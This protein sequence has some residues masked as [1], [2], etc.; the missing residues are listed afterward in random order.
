MYTKRIQL[1]NYGPIDHLD[2]T[3]PFEGD[4]PKPIL[5]VGE[6]GSGKSILL[7][8]IVNGLIL[9]KEVAFPEA[10]EVAPGKVYKLRSNLYIKSGSEYYFAK[11]DFEQGI[12]VSE[13]MSRKNKQDYP[14]VPIGISGT[15]AESMWESMNLT[16]RDHYD[17]NLFENAASQN[18]AKGLL[19]ESCLLYFPSNR[20]EEPAWLNEDNLTAKAKHI[21]VKSTPGDTN[22]K[23]V[24]SSP[25]HDNQNWLFGVGY[26]K[27]AFELK[28]ESMS[29]PPIGGNVTI[30]VP[31]Y[32]GDATTTFQTALYIAQIIT[33]IED[34]K[35]GIG[36]RNNRVIS[37]LSGSGQ[38][39]VPNIF[40]LSS[41]ETSLL[42]LFLSIIRDFDMCE[43]PFSSASD[44]RGIVVVDEIDLHLHAV[45]QHEILP[46]LIRMFPKVQFIVTTHSPL[47]VLGMQRVFG[48]GDFALY[49]M[50]Q[51]QQ[52]SPEQFSEFGDAY[53]AFT[54]TRTFSDDMRAM[55]E[56][57]QKPV[58]FVEGR[59]DQRYIEKASELFQKKAVLESFELRDGGGKGKLVKIWK[60]S[61]LP[62]TEMLPQQVMLLFDCDTDRLPDNKGRLFQRS[63]PFQIQNPIEKG[64]ENLFSKSTLEMARQH[65]A[66]FFITEEEHGGTNENGQPITIPEKWAVTDS[67]KANLC[68]WLCENGTPEDFQHFNLI[69]DLV[70]E[71]LDFTP[72]ILASAES[73]TTQ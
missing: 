70:E 10:P 29:L 60:D 23:V 52:I 68:D 41:G 19:A 61:I 2:I 53:R 36:G 57:S 8:H 48:E 26:D 31:V 14:E 15:P 24:A 17:S 59:T 12:V 20:S 42:N 33:S 71:A 5:L 67:E 38:V 47:F 39:V 7:S 66:A 25:L 65:R 11:V 16:M 21:A 43:A 55:I 62:L 4:N 32:S 63:I 54:A 73:E 22:R 6:N 30:P 44:I 37:L 58:V 51:G 46:N 69:F 56:K 34:A 27:V 13:I 28:I 45:H 18:I 9:A 72:T 49:R 50:P 64:I 35:F 40:Q 1:V 3:F